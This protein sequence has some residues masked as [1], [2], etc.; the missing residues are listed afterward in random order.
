MLSNKVNIEIM[1][2]PLSKKELSQIYS[3]TIKAH[4]FMVK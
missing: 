4:L 1:L 2:L 3:R